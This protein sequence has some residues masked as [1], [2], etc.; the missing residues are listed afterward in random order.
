[1][2][3]S[4]V[5]EIV[6][7]YGSCHDFIYRYKHP[8]MYAFDISEKITFISCQKL[9]IT[10]NPVCIDVHGDNT[11]LS[12]LDTVDER[13]NKQTTKQT[14]KPPRTQTNTQTNKLYKKQGILVN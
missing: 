6:T 8:L 4:F 13:T 3:S 7:S 2:M 9:N 10:V 12:F 1:M 5:V 14:L 11:D